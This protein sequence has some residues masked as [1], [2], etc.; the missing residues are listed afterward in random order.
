MAP[1]SD[2]PLVAKLFDGREKHEAIAR[3]IEQLTPDEAAFFLHKLEH[4]YRKRKIQLS[5]YLVA[6][7]AWLIG[8]TLALIYFGIAPSSGAARALRRALSV[9]W[10][11]FLGKYSYAA[12]I[13]HF[14]IHTVLSS[15]LG[16][17]V[18]SG[19]TAARLLRLA[20][21]VATVGALS[22]VAAMVSWR[23]VEKPFLDLKDRFAP[24][25]KGVSRAPTE[26]S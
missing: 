19:G 5:G 4:A 21:Y 3:A 17:A 12:Y 13:Y 24:R 1:S 16:D 7:V 6:M 23:V 15:H 22:I 20:G 9:D 25:R 14:P 10:L 18:N 2:D 11:R 26:T 8:M